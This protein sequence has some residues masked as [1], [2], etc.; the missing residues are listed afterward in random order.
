MPSFH[1][2]L[3]SWP[4]PAFKTVTFPLIDGIIE[5]FGLERTLK[6]FQFNPLLLIRSSSWAGCSKSHQT[7]PWT[8]WTALRVKYEPDD[9]SDVPLPRGLFCSPPHGFKIF[10][11]GI[12]QYWL[13]LNGLSTYRLASVNPCHSCGRYLLYWCVSAKKSLVPT[14][15]LGLCWF[16]VSIS[17]RFSC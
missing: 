3:G 14:L 4:S 17:C 10:R 6:F 11:A 8:L 9:D 2:V 16:F 1:V 7:W 12:I 15:A 13:F 5:Y